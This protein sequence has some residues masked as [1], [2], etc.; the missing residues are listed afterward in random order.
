MGKRNRVDHRSEEVWKARLDELKARALANWIPAEKANDL[1]A[2][3]PVAPTLVH[4]LKIILTCGGCSKPEDKD[5]NLWIF[6]VQ[7]DLTPE[8]L[9]WIRQAV[10]YLGAPETV[11]E[12]DGQGFT[13]ARYWIWK[14]PK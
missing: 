13:T 2:H 7:R 5:Q 9:V 1:L 8:D 6:S 11:E 10:T 3:S 12:L 14:A 4:D